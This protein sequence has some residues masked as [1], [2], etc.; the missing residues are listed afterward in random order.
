MPDAVFM[1]VWVAGPPGEG[2]AGRPAGGDRRDSGGPDR[3]RR[4][5]GGPRRAGRRGAGAGRGVGSTAAAT[6]VKN[7]PPENAPSV[8][9]RDPGGFPEGGAAGAQGPA[10]GGGTDCRLSGTGPVAGRYGGAGHG[11]EGRGRSRGPGGGGNPVPSGRPPAAGGWVPAAAGAA[12]GKGTVSLP[13]VS[14][15]RARVRAAA[16]GALDAR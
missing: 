3:I 13:H 16:K 4:I 7:G 11:T 8:T 6:P 1:P 2:V 10:D 14:G 5:P 12:R 15:R 9:V